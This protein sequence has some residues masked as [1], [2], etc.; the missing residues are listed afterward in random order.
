M[1]VLSTL[2]YRAHRVT[3]L[4][5][6]GFKMPTSGYSP[7]VKGSKPNLSARTNLPVMERGG[8][9][10]PK[11]PTG[12]LIKPTQASS[13]ASSMLNI[14]I[15]PKEEKSVR[16]SVT[17]N[18][19]PLYSAVDKKSAPGKAQMLKDVKSNDRE[20]EIFYSSDSELSHEDQH[21]VKRNRALVE[22]KV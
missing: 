11:R 2:C 7:H 8:R 22:Q 10:L 12:R 20:K 1:G 15:E 14:S 19:A 4:C 16:K 6:R 13:K 5:C 18:G 3:A 21:H 9:E 17:R